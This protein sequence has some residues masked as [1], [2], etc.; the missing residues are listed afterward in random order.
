MGLVAHWALATDARDAIAGHDGTPRNAVFTGSAA[1]LT[2]GYIEVD[3]WDLAAAAPDAFTIAM[4][5]QL[6]PA[7]KDF[8]RYFASYYYEIDK[9]VSRRDP[10][11]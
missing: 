9:H 6:D 3:G 10:D 11:R 7:T 1:Q 8:D 4:R 5:V 2:G